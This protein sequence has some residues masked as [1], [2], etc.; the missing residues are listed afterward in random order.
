MLYW[1]WA[2]CEPEFATSAAPLVFPPTE[3]Q[4]WRYVQMLIDVNAPA[5]RAMSF[6]EAL[7]MAGEMLGFDV[8]EISKS[9]RI[10][11]AVLQSYDRKAPATQCRELPMA[12]LAVLERAT[13]QGCAEDR[14]AAGFFAFLTHARSRYADGLAIAKEPKIDDGPDSFVETEMGRNRAQRCGLNNP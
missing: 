11:G 2:R 7:E 8:K 12:A 13:E 1:R 3:E 6:V 14:V 10:R 4:A 9:Q 5:T